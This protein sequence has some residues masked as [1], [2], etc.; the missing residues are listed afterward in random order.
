M[1]QEVAERL[2]EM[3]EYIHRHFVSKADMVIELDKVHAAIAGLRLELIKLRGDI[4]AG[5]VKL[6]GEIELAFAR[7]R[8][9]MDGHLH[10]LR[11]E[12]DTNFAKLRGDVE[13]SLCQLE[14]RLIK[15]FI[16]TAI[17]IAGLTFTIAKY[18]A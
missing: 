5:Q 9:E 13:A 1:D 14:T 3:N 6:R 17:T 11:G 7:L 10:R 18:V 15:W 8:G 4:E 12:M 16:G 2:K